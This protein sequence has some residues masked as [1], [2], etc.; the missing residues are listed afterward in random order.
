[1][2][3]GKYAH[4]QRDAQAA[5]DMNDAARIERI[6]AGMW[7]EHRSSARALEVLQDAFD[8]PSRATMAVAFAETA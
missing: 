5:A 6:R 4:L 1:M 8:Q 3:G 7:I 2:S